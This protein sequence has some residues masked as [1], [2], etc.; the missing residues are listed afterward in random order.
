MWE[1]MRFCQVNILCKENWNILKWY[2]RD[3]NKLNIDFLFHLVQ[4]FKTFDPSHIRTKSFC[5]LIKHFHPSY[6]SKFSLFIYSYSYPMSN[7]HRLKTI[8]FTFNIL[9]TLPS[10]NIVVS[11]NPNSY[12][13]A[14]TKVGDL[15]FYIK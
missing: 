2:I 11:S 5:I 12:K 3:K 14:T 10:S 1:S 6:T 7:T 4:C 8:S 9:T 15:V 13:L